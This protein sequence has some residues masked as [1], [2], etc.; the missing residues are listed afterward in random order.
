MLKTLIEK[1]RAIPFVAPFAAFIVLLGLK[2]SFPFDARWEYPIR[3]IIVSAVLL[4]TSG[5][6][7]PRRP[8]RLLSSLI[9]GVLVFAIWIGPDR[10]WPSYRSHWLFQNSLLGEAKSSLPEATHTDF[11]F[12][13]FRLFG[14]AILVPII[15]ELF[16]RGW[17]M[18]Y[19]IHADFQKVPL[20]TYSSTSFWLTAILFATEHGAYWDV[21]LLAGLIYNWWVLRAKSLSDCMIAHGVTNACLAL[22]VIFGGHWEYWL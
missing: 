19:L 7:I 13:V 5:V 22:Y 9:V 1:H 12:L 18:R 10:V 20:G 11:V 8:V 16:W 21:G 14:T 15:E 17:L 6:D 3:V 2:S 4:L